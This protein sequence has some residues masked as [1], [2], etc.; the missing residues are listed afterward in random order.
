M[1]LILLPVV[2]LILHFSV[3]FLLVSTTT[4]LSAVNFTDTPLA[5]K[6]EADDHVSEN[7]ETFEMIIAVFFLS[8]ISLKV[9]PGKDFLQFH[10][11]ANL[12][13]AHD[14]GD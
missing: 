9:I 5:K 11:R 2:L 4:G 6:P 12:K 8:S 14:L 1:S 10:N 13:L 7:K 3:M